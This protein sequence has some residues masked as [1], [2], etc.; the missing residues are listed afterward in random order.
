[1][2]ATMWGPNWAGKEVCLHVPHHKK[3]QVLLH[4][5]TRNMG[6]L[7]LARDIWLI[8]AR[9]DCVLAPQDNIGQPPAIVGPQWCSIPDHLV[10][11]L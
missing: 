7:G 2:A 4:G 11:L 5:R 6:V 3:L 10:Q 8:V 1:V 9:T